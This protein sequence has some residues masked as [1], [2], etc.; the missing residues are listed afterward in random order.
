VAVHDPVSRVGGLLHFMLP[1]SSLDLN[2]ARANPFL[3]ADTGVAVLLQHAYGAGVDKRRMVVRLAGGA[4]VM[5]SKGIFNIG[6]RNYLAVRKVLW[7]A[8]V[9]VH[10]EAVGGVQ[11]RT[12]RLEVGTGRFLLRT[13]GRE[14]VLERG[15]TC[16]A[17]F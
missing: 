6:K 1:E 12:V 16:N 9:M 2:K 11:A 3:F 17:Q 15:N 14:E 5:D 10:A 4:Q 8:G 13:A 7:K